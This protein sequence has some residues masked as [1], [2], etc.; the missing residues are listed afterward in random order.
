MK[1]FKLVWLHIL[2]AV[3]CLILFWSPGTNAEENE[4]NVCFRWAFGAMVGAENDR[5]LVA[6]TRD[7][8]LKG[9]DQIKM[10]V[11][12]KKKCFV[13]LLYHSAEKEVHM[14]FPYEIQ[15]FDTDYKMR[16]K[17]YIPQGTGWFEL[18]ANV[19][20]ESFYLLASARRLV[21]LETL[22]GSYTSAD[23]GKKPELAKQILGE[24]RKLKKAHRKF[25]T[26]AER[27]VAIGGNVRGIKKDK[28]VRTPD[29]DP[30]AAVVSATDFYSK[31]FTIDHQ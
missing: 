14:L 25:T 16:E 2:L 29:L 8:M 1:Y 15:Q 19:G 13:Y 6:I 23:P 7:T 26:T 9:G 20:R 28:V 11:E 17:Y 3:F 10:L 27:P 12:L 22:V 21:R 18:D 30:I 24:I 31:T 5:R 4:K